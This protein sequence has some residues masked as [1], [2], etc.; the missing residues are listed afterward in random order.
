MVKG[1]FSMPL[2]SL[3]GFINYSFKLAQLLLSYPN[4]PRISKRIKMVNVTF[5]TN[6]AGN[7]QHLAIDS[8]GLKAYGKGDSQVK[9]NGINE[10]LRVWRKS[11]LAVDINMSEIIAAE[12]HALNVTDG[13][14]LHNAL[15]Q[16]H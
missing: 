5:K 9:K 16:T 7:V 15:K 10:Q 12:F 1:L 4:Y 2:R 14:V 13:T 11:H 3:P 8:T 6:N